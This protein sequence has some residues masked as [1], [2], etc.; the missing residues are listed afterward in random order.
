MFSKKD[1]DSGRSSMPSGSDSDLSDAG[2][3]V[4]ELIF[5]GSMGEESL[6]SRGRLSGE[7]A[8]E[9]DLDTV[10]SLSASSL[11]VPSFGGGGAVKQVSA[12]R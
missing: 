5:D 7:Y 4:D 3:A 12:M 8:S 6:R 11:A 2:D 10:A 1:K 9:E